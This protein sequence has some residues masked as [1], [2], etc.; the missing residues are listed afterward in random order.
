MSRKFSIMTTIN[1]D[2]LDN[3]IGQYAKCNGV[4]DPYIFMNEDTINTIESEVQNEFG[5][6][7]KDINSNIKLKNGI[8][9]TYCGYKVFINNDL[10]FGEV[11]IR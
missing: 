10:R 3:E 8:Q 7:V 11:E 9:A 5:F 2:R 6:D 4:F 1:F